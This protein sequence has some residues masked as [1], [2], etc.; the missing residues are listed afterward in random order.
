MASR[1]RL[2]LI[3]L[4][5][6]SVRWLEFQNGDWSAWSILRSAKVCRHFWRRERV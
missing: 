1:L 3:S 2:L 6:L 5:S 4:A